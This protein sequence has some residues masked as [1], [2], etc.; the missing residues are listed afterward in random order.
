M[1]D[2]NY[3]LINMED[4]VAEEVEWLWEGYIPI[5]KLTILQGDPG[6]GKTMA[7]LN[8]IAAFTTGRGMLEP[9][10]SS[11]IREPINVIYQTAEDGLADTVK[12][13]LEAAGADCSRVSVIDDRDKMLSMTDERLVWAIRETKAGLVVLDPLQAYLGEKVDMNRANEVRPRLKH[14]GDIA[15]EN[16]CGMVLVGH[17]NKK[18]TAK[19]E[20]KGL[21]SMDF[22]AAARSVILCAESPRDKDLRV[23]AST[24]CSLTYPPDPVAFRLSRERG[25]EW[26][27]TYN[28]TA[29]ELLQSTSIKGQ[30]TIEA[31]EFLAAEL[32]APGEYIPSTVLME[33]AKEQKIAEKTLRNAMKDLGIESHKEA[34]RWLTGYAI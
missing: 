26:E 1:E 18:E 34:D 7:M 9:P 22:T 15:Y 33:K 2:N 11:M 30:K 8:L 17:L 19:P 13:R 5:G 32:P 10:W 14:L 21:G 24:K 23:L 16:R 4:V 12:P 20:Y 25:F 28:I 3:R 6:K 27:G 29:E 31:K